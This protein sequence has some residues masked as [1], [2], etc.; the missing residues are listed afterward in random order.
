V[1]TVGQDT[2]TE[3]FWG[4]LMLA[5]AAK[6]K[7]IPDTVYLSAILVDQANVDKWLSK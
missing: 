4:M 6:G 2:Y 7:R 3:E 5:E 1:G